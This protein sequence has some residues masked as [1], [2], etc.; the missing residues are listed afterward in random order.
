M[1]R[2]LML[3]EDLARPIEPSPGEGPRRVHRR[4]LIGLST[5]VGRRKKVSP[6][7]RVEGA[8]GKGLGCAPVEGLGYA[9][10]EG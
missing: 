8:R 7:G 9:P 2:S 6:G 3:A 10:V 5:G 4:R 1:K